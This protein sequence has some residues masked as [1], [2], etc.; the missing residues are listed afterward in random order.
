M[1]LVTLKKNKVQVMVMC[2]HDLGIRASLGHVHS[3][4]WDFVQVMAMCTA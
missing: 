3:M 1:K 2:T 4:T